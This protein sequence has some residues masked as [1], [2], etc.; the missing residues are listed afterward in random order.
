MIKNIFLL[1][2]ETFTEW[3]EDKASRLAAALAYYT[4]FSLAPLLVIIIAIA[5]LFL[6]PEAARGQINNQVDNLIGE[7]GAEAIETLIQNASQHEDLGIVATI[8]G[9]V[10]LLFGAMG[11][12][13]QLYDS[14]NA[15]WEVY[16]LNKKKGIIATILY[17]LQQRLLSFVMV[18]GVG[19]LLLVS[20]VISAALSVLGEF[21]GGILPV[22]EVVMQ[23]LNLIVSLAVITVMFALLYKFV[24]EAKVAWKDVWIGALVTA[25]LFTIGKTLIGLYLGH[26]S[27][28]S[29][30]GA[31]ASFIVI[32]LW[33]YYSALI[34]FLGAEFTQV[35]AREF[36][37][38]IV[39]NANAIQLP[40]ITTLRDEA[41]AA[42]EAGAPAHPR[43]LAR[44]AVERDAAFRAARGHV[45]AISN[46]A[47]QDK[48]GQRDNVVVITE[49]VPKDVGPF[50]AM[51]L[52]FWTFVA[53]ILLGL[54]RGSRE[55]QA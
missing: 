54:M 53:G 41:V 25:I 2:R 32:M 19:F 18:L 40:D 51:F 10:T 47:L 44:R 5:G 1:I 22:P 20:L 48:K 28:A 33:V 36:G 29:S 7:Q 27:T 9:I 21:A 17:T 13:G 50:A 39:P 12:F 15:I 34:L 52:A 24:P 4:L 49:E 37:H 6:G 23:M 43:D 35:Y 3:T 14:L 26:S 38:G 8:V 30:F 31:A 45:T 11:V 55:K 46:V 16:P 42:A